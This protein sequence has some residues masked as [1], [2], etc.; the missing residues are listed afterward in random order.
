[1][2]SNGSARELERRRRLAVERLRDGRTQQDVADFLGVHP[3]TVG[4]W[5]AAHRDG[6]DAGLAA[7]PTPGRPRRLTADQEAEVLSWLGQRPTAF[8]FDTDL[9]T[10]PRVARLIERRFGVRFHPRYVNA[11]LAD[12][13]ITPQKP[14]HRAKERDQPAIDHWTAEDWPRLQKKRRRRRPTLS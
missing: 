4:R 9:W 3:R 2:R 10:A 11:W 7:K 8:G 12:R 1:M 13:H 14:T 6:G 5:W